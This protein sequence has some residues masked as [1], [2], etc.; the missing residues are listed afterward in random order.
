MDLQQRQ[1]PIGKWK[2]KKNYS[3]KE[4]SRHLAVIEKYP[5]KYKRLVKKLT[6]SE[7]AKTY[8][9]GAWNA[10]QLVVHIADMHILHYARVKQA[11]CTDKP[12]AYTANI[13]GWNSLPEVETASPVEALTLLD[14]THKRYAHLIRSMSPAD[15][16][17][18]FY[19]PQ[20]QIDINLAQAIHMTAW[21]TRHH[22]EHIKLA[23]GQ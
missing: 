5:A 2:P 8:R 3:E 17:R 13:D 11:L 7:W 9:A 19:H 22:F 23:L 12:T 6:P 15:F 16:E 14:A 1:F 10:H 20:R 4:M 21:H 18:S